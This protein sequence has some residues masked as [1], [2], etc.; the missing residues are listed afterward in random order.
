MGAPLVRWAA[1]RRP[2][3]SGLPHL[4]LAAL[5]LSLSLLAACTP[6]PKEISDLQTFDYAGGDVRS[7]SVAY[8][9]SPPAG[10][11]YNAFWQT[12]GAYTAPVYDEYAVHTLARGAVWVTYQPGLGADALTKLKAVLATPL[13]VPNSDPPRTRVPLSLLSPRENLPAPIVMTAWNAQIT[14]QNADD[15]R[16]KLFVERYG[17]GTQ[18]PEAG[19]GCANGFSETR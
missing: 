4:G 3:L 18:A 12:C 10:G 14:A 15:E 11:P 9:I 8:D 7:G 19:G 6:A 2:V 1:M 17:L 13:S 16:L 5:G